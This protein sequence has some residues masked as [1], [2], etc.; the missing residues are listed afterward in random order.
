MTNASVFG[1]LFLL[2]AILVR[3][4]ASHKVKQNHNHNHNRK[5]QSLK[6]KTKENESMTMNKSFL[7]PPGKA[8]SFYVWN[9]PSAGLYR[10]CHYLQQDCT[11]EGKGGRKFI[12][13]RPG[14]LLHILHPICPKSKDP[15]LICGGNYR[16]H[17]TLRWAKHLYRPF[18]LHI[19]RTFR[20]G[21][22]NLELLETTTRTKKKRQ[23]I[24]VPNPIQ[25][26]F[27]KRY[28]KDV[29]DRLSA[30]N[31][32]ETQSGIL[33]QQ[34]KKIHPFHSSETR[35]VLLGEKP[36]VVPSPQPSTLQNLVF[37]MMKA[38]VLERIDALINMEMLEE[39]ELNSRR[40]PKQ[41]I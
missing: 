40:Q 34:T 25:L 1:W 35:T 8:C 18:D 16:D 4:T 19:D 24:P 31:N 9:A 36:N 3:I 12:Y 22:R 30:A 14:S 28:M 39:E 27:H 15:C 38:T 7:S 10:L 29:S 26:S 11:Y 32:E 21:Y 13:I 23:R 20:D 37:R 6:K 41:F 2:F 33:E 5:F 17:M